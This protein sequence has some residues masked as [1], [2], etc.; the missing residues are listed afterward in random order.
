MHNF[1]QGI[2]LF[3]RSLKQNS[4]TFGYFA[5]GFPLEL[6]SAIPHHRSNSLYLQ[7]AVDVFVLQISLTILHMAVHVNPATG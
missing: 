2:V 3:S 6:Q 7:T 4:V 5:L 1:I